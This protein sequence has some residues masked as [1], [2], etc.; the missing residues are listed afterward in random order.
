M[1]DDLRKGLLSSRFRSAEPLLGI[2][3]DGAA[4]AEAAPAQA[5]PTPPC[6][7]NQFFHSNQQ[8][9]ARARGLRFNVYQSLPRAADSSESVPVFV[10]HHGAGSSAL[11]FAPLARE[12]TS[13]T[14]CGTFAFDARG[15]GLTTPLR[16]QDSVSFYNADFAQDFQFLIEQLRLNCQDSLPG[17]NLR[18][19]LVGHSLGGSICASVFSELTPETRALV[20]GVA[21]LDVV[22]EAAVAALASVDTFLAKTPS[23]F[24][25]MTDAIDWHIKKGY[26]NCRASAEI[27]IPALFRPLPS[28][29]V[30]RITNLQVFRP[31]WHTWFT[32]FSSRFVDLPTAKLLMLAGSD[33]LDKQLI[34][35][36]MRGKFQLVVFQESGH[37]IQEDTSIKTAITLLDFY[38]RNG[39]KTV[40]IKT[41]WKSRNVKTHNSS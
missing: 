27:A 23:V 40:V 16:D 28:G 22:E 34:V 13:R 11:T 2:S 32:G 5:A 30:V 3:E 9:P 20:T 29:K 17:V 35:G 38:K 33:H 12:L 21:A 4:P 39:S 24:P 7:W 15:H 8:I 19:V 6:Y 37:F 31:Y 36:Q 14:N 26:S 18:F 41:N 10:F 1:S 25:N